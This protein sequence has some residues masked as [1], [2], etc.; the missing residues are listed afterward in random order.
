[1]GQP[2]TRRQAS[3]AKDGYY[4][5]ETHGPTVVHCLSNEAKNY[6][7]VATG[8]LNAR[9]LSRQIS[10]DR[11]YLNPRI[12]AERPLIPVWWFL[13]GLNK[14]A[15]NKYEVMRFRVVNFTHDPF[16]TEIEQASATHLPAGSQ[17]VAHL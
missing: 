7:N 5:P 9:H 1:L 16:A 14:S 17:T 2:W 12:G 3:G 13:Q 6:Q 8:T 4:L 11:R 15:R 10:K